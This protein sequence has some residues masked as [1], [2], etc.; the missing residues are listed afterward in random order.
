MR[1]NKVI[2]KIPVFFVIALFCFTIQAAAPANDN[3]A[4]A[5]TVVITG[6]FYLGNNS[7]ATK[8][9]I[10]PNHGLNA[11]GKSIWY[12][13]VATGEGYLSVTTEGSAFDTTLAIYRGTTL[14]NLTLIAEADDLPGGSVLQSRA[15]VATY[16]GQTYYIA[17]DGKNTDGTVASGSTTVDFT[18][19]STPPNDA[20]A[21]A[22]TLT[23]LG[24]S[25]SVSNVNATKET[26]EPNHG[27]DVGGHSVWYR[28]VGPQGLTKSYTF[29]TRGSRTQLGLNGI[30]SIIGIYTGLSVNNLTHVVSDNG[31]AQVSFIPQPGIIYYIGIDTRSAAQLP[32]AQG[33]VRLKWGITGSTDA[34]DFDRDD[35]SDIAVFRPS[36]GTWY[37]ISS[38]TGNVSSLNWGLGSDI[39]IGADLDQDGKTDQTV[40][41]PSTGTWYVRRSLPPNDTFSFQWG[42]NG[43]IPQ[44]YRDGP[45]TFA[46]VFRPSDGTWYIRNV[47]GF[48]TVRFGL[49]GDIPVMGDYD[50]DGISDVAVFRPSTGVWYR[51]NSSSGQFVA[52]EFGLNG[53]KPVVGDYD[54]DGRADIALYRPSTGIW[55]IL[56]SKTGSVQAS[57]WG[58]PEDIPQPGDYD[59]DNI[60]DLAVFR[61]STGVWY[62]LRSSTSTP[63]ITSFG[64]P[65][66]R[67]VTSMNFVP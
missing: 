4:N 26:G 2:S 40:F 49:A 20:F 21:S 56:K 22:L 36:T 64:L 67:P 3:F 31:I 10:E 6:S 54:N 44:I 60:A 45:I 19:G 14:A 61:P 48:I 51:L 17:V 46:A 32:N 27:G 23:P 55:W 37:S 62:V 13:Y 9:A 16:T 11:G 24:G 8:E 25:L 42:L 12:K 63:K 59:G 50:G 43:D 15:V 18:T 34:S 35:K 53:D 47:Y 1:G 7:E 30:P 33:T 65:G 39:P 28:F 38:I 5:E 57:A 52:R 58:L 41:R 66:D 29:S